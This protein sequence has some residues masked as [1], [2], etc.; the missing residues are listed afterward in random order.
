MHGFSTRAHSSAKI[1]TLAAPP[2]SCALDTY[3]ETSVSARMNVTRMG[4]ST[5]SLDVN[6][7]GRPSYD[8]QT[9][10]SRRNPYV[11][12]LVGGNNVRVGSRGMYA[13]QIKTPLGKSYRPQQSRV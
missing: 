5:Q 7:D 11:Y 12:L 13:T 4:I 3:E 6:L 1:A 9:Q 10:V 8:A 2:G